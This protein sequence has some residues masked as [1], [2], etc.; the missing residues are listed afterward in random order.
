MRDGGGGKKID[1]F[2][3]RRIDGFGSH[4][5]RRAQRDYRGYGVRHQIGGHCR[6]PVE[7][8]IGRAIFDCE[9]APLDVAT[10]L[11]VLPNGADPSII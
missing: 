10:I 11:E 9:I 5:G 2:F 6:Q 4:C 7:A 8:R 3:V 1:R